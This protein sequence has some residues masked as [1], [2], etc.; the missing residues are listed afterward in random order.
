MSSLDDDKVS[1]LPLP[2]ARIVTIYQRFNKDMIEH[3][4][5]PQASGHPRTSV[6]YLIVI[7]IEPYL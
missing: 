4:V 6:L 2:L 5:F 3:S 7:L 1:P